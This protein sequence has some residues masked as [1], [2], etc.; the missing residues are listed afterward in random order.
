VDGFVGRW[1]NAKVYN[2]KSYHPTLSWHG[3][4][5]GILSISILGEQQ[6]TGIHET[7]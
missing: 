3:A 5:E 7:R 4:A 1:V 2:A 6:G